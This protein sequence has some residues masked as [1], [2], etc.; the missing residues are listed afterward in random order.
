MLRLGIIL[1]TLSIASTSFAHKF[2]VSITDL[3]YNQEKER[4]EG[5]I[6]MTAHDFELILEEK[7]KRKIDLDL[8]TDSSEV[9]RYIQ[10]YLYE[11][12]KITSNGKTSVPQYFGKEITLE[13]DLF[14][15]FIF[16]KVADPKS[17]RITNTIL[18]SHFA[19][20]Q[21]IVHYQYKEQTKTVTL[22]PSKTHEKIQFDD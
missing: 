4:I 20:Q 21:N 18:F 22:V 3:E 15:Y 19:K 14:I 9:G 2:Y 5:S 12:F 11:N 13:Q 6:K 16:T 17:I 10:L 7:F 1:F 8:V